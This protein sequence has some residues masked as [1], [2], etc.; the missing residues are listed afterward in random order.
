MR[1]IGIQGS[2]MSPDRYA[3]SICLMSPYRPE[4]YA[5]VSVRP[6][7]HRRP[8]QPWLKHADAAI[9]YSSWNHLSTV[10]PETRT[11]M[12]R[13]GPP[14]GSTDV[15]TALHFPLG[16]LIGGDLSANSSTLLSLSL[17]CPSSVLRLAVGFLLFFLFFL[18][19]DKNREDILILFINQGKWNEGENGTK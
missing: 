8:P 5:Q 4:I 3:R 10:R 14:H 2:N 1:I 13:F 19:K 6:Y 9:I 7:I 15:V 16:R 11:T 17:F 12:R 18:S